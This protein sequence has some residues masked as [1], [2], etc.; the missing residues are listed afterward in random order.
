MQL[1]C[2]AILANESRIQGKDV[3]HITTGC[4]ILYSLIAHKAGANKV[5]CVVNGHSEVEEK[6]VYMMKQIV[7]EN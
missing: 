4:N 5:Y 1:F 7:K 3:L 2:E 6:N